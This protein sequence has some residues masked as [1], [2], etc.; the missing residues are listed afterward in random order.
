MLRAADKDAEAIQ[1][2]PEGLVNVALCLQ[3][4][5]Q[6]QKKKRNAVMHV[7]QLHV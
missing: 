7:F 2:I 3:R 6:W 1:S 4:Q 5:Q